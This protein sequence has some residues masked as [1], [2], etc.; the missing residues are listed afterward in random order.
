MS[1]FGSHPLRAIIAP[2][3]LYNSGYACSNLGDIWI[4]M[5]FTEISDAK[6]VDTNVPVVLVH[7]PYI[8]SRQGFDF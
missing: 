5:T 6:P 4:F 2:V 7:A 8:Q 1:R 3:V